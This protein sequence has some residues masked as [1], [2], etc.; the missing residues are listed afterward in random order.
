[1]PPKK[2]I[3][4]KKRPKTMQEQ[5]QAASHEQLVS[6]FLSLYEESDTAFQK[7][8]N[9]MVLSLNPDS[10]DI[11]K[12]VD[13]EM[14]SLETSRR[15]LDPTAG[16]ALISRLNTLR[17]MVFNDLAKQDATTA[18]EKMT[19]LLGSCIL[20][21]ERLAE[22]RDLID[23]AYDFYNE[24]AKNLGSIVTD[25]KV[26]EGDLLL[27]FVSVFFLTLPLMVSE[28]FITS[29]APALKNEGLAE[30]VNLIKT[31][32]LESV[33]PS[34]APPP[35]D[36]W[37][38][39]RK[40]TLGLKVIADL[41]NNIDAYIE[42]CQ[43]NKTKPTAEECLDIAQRLIKVWRTGE[44]ITWLTEMGNPRDYED[45]ARRSS[46]L[47]EAF[48]LDG[49]SAKAQEE[50]FRWFS[51]TLEPSAFQQLI[52]AAPKGESAVW[53][54]KALNVVRECKDVHV[55][56]NCFYRLQLVDELA[57]LTEKKLDKLDVTEAKLFKVLGEQL[58]TDY[59]KLTV[60]LYRKFIDAVLKE[61]MTK[62]YP[63]AATQL[64]ACEELLK[65]VATTEGLS[66]HEDYFHTV[67]TTHKRKYS[68]WEAYHEALTKPKSKTTTKKKITSDVLSYNRQ[69]ERV[70]T[71]LKEER[72][73]NEKYRPIFYAF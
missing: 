17:Q 47:V 66:S 22:E 39:Q 72:G 60:Q 57:T 54:A 14:K 21:W 40:Q 12:L 4:P 37:E 46:L 28:A 69:F 24:C 1:M 25:Y 10:K 27:E 64:L 63:L 3:A 18:A 71:E 30:L 58:Q 41:T 45:K 62:Q 20:V 6:L 61:G 43:F 36:R 19:E 29:F 53:E 5:L 31:V 44:A 59:P 8:L 34:K 23:K 26:F 56:L 68:F 35:M 38:L 32:I 73:S 15:Y 49:D 33:D 11:V 70:V 16:K 65:R 50:R 42:A 67:K 51:K 2:T 7:R 48:D 13:K 9:L 55:A 52:L